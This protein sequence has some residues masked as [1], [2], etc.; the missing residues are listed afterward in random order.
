LLG[1]LAV[2]QSRVWRRELLAMPRKAAVIYIAVALVVLAVLV[3]AMLPAARWERLPGQMNAENPRWISTQVLLHM[4][5]DAGAWGLGPGTFAVT[6]PH[7]TLEVGTAIRGIWRFAHQDYLQTL[8]EWGWAGAGVWAIL[9]FGG[10]LRSFHFCRRMR[11]E[12]NALLFTGGLALTGVALHALVDF[13]L[14]IASLQLYAAVYL[15]LGWGSGAWP[16]DEGRTSPCQ[17][18]T[19][20]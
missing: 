4:L 12:E 16:A 1:A 20:K 3:V 8:I 2:W 17:Q 14:Q 9:F 6:F 10:L 15:G 18:L 7:Y 11:S 19:S 13:P 5:P